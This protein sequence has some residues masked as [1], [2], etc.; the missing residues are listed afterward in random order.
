VRV[1]RAIQHA[2]DRAAIAKALEGRAVPAGTILPPG[3]PGYDPS[4]AIYRYDPERAAAL[5][6]EA[7]FADSRDLPKL[8]LFVGR[9]PGGEALIDELGKEDLFILGW[10]ADFPDPDNFFEPL[11]RTDARYNFVHYSNPA[12]DR[13]IADARHKPD[14]VERLKAYR[15]MERTILEDAV[16]A[17]LFHDASLHCLNPAVKNL[18]VGPLGIYYTPI[19]RAYKLE[20]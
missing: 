2:L 20:E 3:M 4:A 6:E 14:K 1:R 7:G 12:L 18:V 11:F 9:L 5:L 8:K 17:P 16:V 15:H 19:K 10:G 13:E